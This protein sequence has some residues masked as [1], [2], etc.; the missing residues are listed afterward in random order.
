MLPR[1]GTHDGRFHADEV[2]AIAALLLIHPG[3]EIVR[4]R[5]EATL[6][7]CDLR[8]DV[9]RKYD[10]ATGDF[11]HHQ[12]GA[13]T[14]KNGIQFSSFGL[15]WKAFGVRAVG[16]DAKAAR[17]IENSLVQSVDA[18]DNGQKLSTPAVG[19]GQG[20][21]R[22]PLKPTFG[23]A[24]PFEF[25]S[26][27]D[28]FNLCW[29]ADERSPD[30]AF[31]EAV[32]FAKRMLARLIKRALATNRAKQVVRAG[33]AAAT[34]DPRVVVLA[35]SCPWQGTIIDESPRALYV[36]LPSPDGKWRVECVPKRTGAFQY[37][38]ALPA[39]WQD[40]DRDG[41][42]AATG[43]PDAHFVHQKLFM[44]VAGSFEGALALA[45]LALAA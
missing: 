24:M 10:P 30:E 1:I 26:A 20:V 22:D 13:G 9:G 38:K 34:Y 37:R 25:V 16:G 8:V 19:S 39:A 33:V 23:G 14:R 40:L 28:A 44:C 11:D 12:G 5:D 15:I 7:T 43:V 3:A 45:K 42:I 41:F 31:H 4:T 36:I 32:E 18:D 35:H 29:D 27:I 6:S 21:D 17:F 2:L